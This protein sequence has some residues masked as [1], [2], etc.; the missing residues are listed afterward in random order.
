MQQACHELEE[1][2]SESAE[3]LWGS[4]LREDRSV[5][6]ADRWMRFVFLVYGSDCI[7]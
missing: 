7:M 3:R 6:E 1:E 4:R 5:C 2:C